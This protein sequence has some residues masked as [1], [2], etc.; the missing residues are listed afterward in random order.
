[1]RFNGVLAMDDAEKCSEPREPQRIPLT[2]KGRKAKMTAWCLD[3][4]EWSQF[5]KGEQE[6]AQRQ[7]KPQ[8]EDGEKQ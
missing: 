6:A 4:H 7:E 5:R 8:K 2:P 3:D 1:M